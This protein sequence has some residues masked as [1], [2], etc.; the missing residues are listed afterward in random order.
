MT[1]YIL[2]ADDHFHGCVSVYYTGAVIFLQTVVLLVFV[3]MSVGPW[4]QSLDL[5]HLKLVPFRFI[6]NC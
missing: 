6:G 1:S 5:E 2:S 4:T 3:L